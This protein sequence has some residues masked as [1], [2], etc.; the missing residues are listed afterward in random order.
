[1]AAAGAPAPT[2][3][4]LYTALLTGSNPMA[5]LPAGF[6]SASTSAVAPSATGRRHHVV[7]EVE[8]SLDYGDAVILYAVFPTRQD[9]VGYWEDSDLVGRP[10][11]TAHLP[12]A[13]FPA[14]ALI[15]DGTT[16]LATALAETTVANGFTVLGFVDGNV[17]VAVS[18]Y[19]TSSSG[20]NVP[21]ALSLG[22]LALERLGALE[23]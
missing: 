13:G 16:A 3:Q 11:V 12:A 22:R 8:V 20:G 21:A 14:P 6:S 9:A 1:V 4:A 5:Q 15:V 17:S 23:R 19:S 18:T 7:G 10:G 2:A